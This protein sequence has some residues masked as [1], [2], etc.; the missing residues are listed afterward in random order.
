MEQHFMDP[1][2]LKHG[3]L[4]ES[5]IFFGTACLYKSKTKGNKVTI[6]YLVTLG[7][8]KVFGST[9]ITVSEKYDVPSYCC[10]INLLRI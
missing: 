1:K 7:E 5:V 10:F 3:A 4:F 2:T 9:Y 8:I 6:N